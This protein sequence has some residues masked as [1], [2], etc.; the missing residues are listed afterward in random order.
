MIRARAE[1]VINR[2]PEEV[3]D[4]WADARNENDWDPDAKGVEKTSP[5]PVGPGATFRG[6]YSEY[7][8]MGL[9]TLENVE[10]ERPRKLRRSASGKSFRFGST[11]IF[12]PTASGGTSVTAT[13]EVGPR[14]LFKLMTPIMG[15]TMKKKFSAH[16][17]DFQR[18]LERPT[19]PAAPG[20]A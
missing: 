10:Y 20:H 2:S 6:E 8:G 12:S 5:G 14:G 13:G 15:P 7:K 1:L 11:L 19:S 17:A 4:F 3:F 9:L 18:A 16:M